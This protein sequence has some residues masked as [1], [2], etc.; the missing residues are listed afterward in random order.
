MSENA[1][2]AP[3]RDKMKGVAQPQ[4]GLQFRIDLILT[5]LFIGMIFF[6]LICTL[7]FVDGLRVNAFEMKYLRFYLDD[8]DDYTPFEL[9]EASINS[10]G[11]FIASNLYGTNEL[12]MIN[13]GFQY[14]LGKRLVSTGG[15]QMI[16]LNTGHLYDLQTEMSMEGG[17]DDI[18]EMRN[19][20]PADTP[21]LFVYEHPTLYD[22][23]AQMPKGYGFLDYGIQEADEVVSL[24]REAG[25]DVLDS[26]DVLPASGVPMDEYLMRT[27]QHWSTRAAMLMAQAICRRA[28]ELTGRE[29]PEE[30]LDIEQFD[31]TVYP[32]L[33][34]GKYG[35]RVGTLMI[36]PDDITVYTPKYETELHVRTSNVG[37]VRELDGPF[38]KVQVRPDALKTPEGQSWN[39]RGY[40]Y[41]GLTEDY[42]IST[43][44]DGGD[45]TILL[46]KDSYS[47][48]IGRFLSLAAD[49][50]YS[51]DLRSYYNEKTL[52]DYIEECDPDIVVVAYSLQMLR[53]EQYEFQ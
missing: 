36:E 32:K 40:L 20:V 19:I 46:L 31:T 52:A 17:R 27:D 24:V 28:E 22:E 47:A 15:T 14:A 21:F 39:T 16:R 44:P 42:D 3:N 2:A 7:L 8:P 23:D 35:Q 12:G 38:E 41:Y 30:R 4:N 1:K 48:P 51:V 9:V 53:D 11:D 18:V 43:N 29:L 45:C 6:F 37:K 33:F 5:V 10:T 13:A 25:I 26:R 34:L 50:V 49:E